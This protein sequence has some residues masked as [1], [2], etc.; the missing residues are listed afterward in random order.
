M[1]K[2]IQRLVF[3]SLIVVVTVL[4]AV[5]VRRSAA[6]PS[7]S[8]ALQ[9]VGDV[10]AC[11][12]LGCKPGAASYSQDDG[13]TLCRAPLEA[14]G[15][16]GTFY[17]DGSSTLAWFAPA[18]AAGH[19]V[20]SH[21]ANHMLNCTI[22]PSCYPN[23]TLQSLYQTPYT[24]QDV[25][26]FRQNQIEP[27]L[28]AIEAG[29]NRPVLSLAYPCGATDA[30][31]MIA[32]NYYFLGA[33]GYL[34][35]WSSNFPWAL[36]INPVTPP[37]AMLLN[38]DD[39]FH[40]ALVDRAISE[41]KWAILTMHD[42]CFGIDYLTAHQ[43]SLWIAPVGEVLKYIRVRNAT[44]IS[45]YSRV[46]DVINFDAAS[47]LANFQRQRV[48]GSFMTPIVFDN[49]ISLRVGLL[50]ADN[51]VNVLVNGVSTGFTVMSI[52]NARYVV[53][54]SPV[55]LSRHVIINITAGTPPTNT[56]TPAPTPT[57]TTS[58]PAATV[59]PGASPTPTPTGTT[60]L[61]AAT[62]TATSPAAPVTCPC[63]LW[64][65]IVVPAEPA[66]G[67]V[68]SLELGVRFQS[69]VAGYITGLRFY[70]GATNVG[71]HT[72]QLY[73]PNGTLL[74]SA[75]FVNETASGWQTVSF[76]N[77]VAIAANTIYVASYVAPIGHF[78]VD[79]SYFN[80][81][82]TRGPLRAF[83]TTEVAGG[84]G[85]YAQ[86]SGFPTLSYMASNYWVDVIFDTTAP[87]PTATPT[88]MATSLP[89]NTPTAT[90]LPTNT[91]TA[92]ATSLPINTPTA[93]ATSLP[94]NTPTATATR[95]STAT[96]T[97]TPIATATRTSTATRTPTVTRTPTSTR[98]NTPTATV[99]PINTGLLSPNANAPA[100][101]GDNNGYETTPA[102]IYTS[103]SLYGVD[104]NSGTS[105]SASCAHAGKDRHVFSAYNIA[106][107]AT[108][109]VLGIEIRADARVD[110]AANSPVLCIE[111]SGDGGLTWTAVKTTATLNTSLRTYTLGTATDT[112]GRAW[113]SANLS[114]SNFQVRI[115]NVSSSTAR[116]FS[117]DWLAARVTY[118]P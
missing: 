80:A 118:R 9:T 13:L 56:A 46:G 41:G 7:A 104:T 20:G 16:R 62:P 103:N 84:N 51:V 110:S 76:I 30:A 23:C 114:N 3:G 79:R 18:S 48:D 43:S 12:W 17:Y 60:S 115:T 71:T 28:S 107:P 81:G 69:N 70:K 53:F 85:I 27:N 99:A 87:A 54:N 64:D 50:S 52:N 93:T 61:P 77:P 37:E 42:T 44:Q 55:N 11:T 98:T 66:V 95:T 19:E 106:L 89:T 1:S 100:A 14:A 116:D 78:A 108:A 97:N 111:L 113:T 57:G 45:N 49:P 4:F 39:T 65:N 36:D 82:Y 83:G 96:R 15:F 31:R 24:A 117:L 72:G 88:A 38:S 2:S 40:P 94:T 29:T 109:T 74:T 26:N 63:S 90:S 68:G 34:D 73:A 35:I 58:L 105:T 8:P 59:T 47:P 33:R 102:N 5:A 32:S 10:T 21:L 6:A 25:T 67:D 91:P 86:P 101:G 112:W 92:T 75:T 22:P